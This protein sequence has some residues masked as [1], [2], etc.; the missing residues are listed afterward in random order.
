VVTA[1][2]SE[3]AERV[4]EVTERIPQGCVMSYGDIA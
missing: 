2:P 1:H 4:L 3:F